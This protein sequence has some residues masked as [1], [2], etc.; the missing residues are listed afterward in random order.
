MFANE[1]Q[2]R[3]EAYFKLVIVDRETLTDLLNP[4]DV[5]KFPQLVRQS[6]FGSNVLVSFD[7]LDNAIDS[8]E[9]GN[10]LYVEQRHQKIIF[11][12]TGTEP[13]S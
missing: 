9:Q 2:E 7:E 4:N 10:S 11:T 1:K 5:I 6:L 12:L 8:L 3:N 13:L